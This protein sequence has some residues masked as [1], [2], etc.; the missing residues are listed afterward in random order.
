MT[1]YKILLCFYFFFHFDISDGN[2]MLQS[3]VVLVLSMTSMR[4]KE[5]Q[6]R[7]DV[8]LIVEQRKVE[9]RKIEQIYLARFKFQI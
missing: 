7:E 9:L 4:E 8:D 2:S 1:F 6:M 5:G 3:L